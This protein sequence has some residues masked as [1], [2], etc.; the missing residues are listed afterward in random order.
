MVVVKYARLCS[1]SVNTDE[2]NI[3][4]DGTDVYRMKSNKPSHLNSS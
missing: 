1:L 4:F 2:G 3:D